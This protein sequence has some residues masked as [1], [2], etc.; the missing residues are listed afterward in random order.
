MPHSVDRLKVFL[1]MAPVFQMFLCF[2]TLPGQ[3]GSENTHDNSSFQS[4]LNLYNTFSEYST[5]KF[6]NNAMTFG[7]DENTHKSVSTTGSDVNY[8]VAVD[9]ADRIR[10]TTDTAHNSDSIR[11]TTDTAYNLSLIHISE[12]TRLA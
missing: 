4:D 7:A 5:P 10:T 3:T 12:P 2:L 8:S 6:N 1:T 9:N 11:T